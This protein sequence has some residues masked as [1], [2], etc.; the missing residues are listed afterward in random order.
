MAA[1]SVQSRVT[2]S[3]VFSNEHVAAQRFYMQVRQQSLALIE[4]LSAEDCALQASAFVS[5]A[6]WHLA[7]TTW[8]FET[9]ILIPNISGYE[10]FN[11]HFQVLFNS[12]YNG[13]GE[14]F[15]RPKRH[16]LSRPSL[17][18]VQLYRE[19]VDQ[20]M[21]QCLSV[22]FTKNQPEVAKLITLGLHHEM[23]H[24]ELLLMDLKYSFFQNPLFPVYSNSRLPISNTALPLV[25]DSIKGGIQQFGHQGDEFHF[26]NE[27]PRH[28]QFVADFKMANRQ[29]TNGEYLEFM[30][31]GGYESALLWLSDGWA[32]LK[33][34]N[35]NAAPLYWVMQQDQWFEFTLHGL[36]AL[37]LNAP[38]SHINFYEAH[39]YS[40]WA[41]KRLPTESEWEMVANQSDE[42][43]TNPAFG[44]SFN[45][46]NSECLFNQNWIWT[47][48]AY[49]PYPG[50]K[51]AEGAVGEYNGKFMC[52]QMVLRGGCALTPS[53]HLRSTY[54]NF[55]YPQDRWPMTGLRLAD[56]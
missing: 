39:A 56:N 40:Q 22:N 42:S 12:Y 49:Q 21:Q 46:T 23:Q 14:Q 55:F 2:P 15:L 50:Y 35:Q 16:L 4:P 43:L 26:D 52:N 36:Q 9:F 27:Q 6:K 1:T 24:Q 19:H 53:G 44:Q 10:P 13:V 47:S 11:T 30:K 33:Q 51:A 20:A 18:E 25:F 48:S 28:K 41:Q 5:P 3:T 32:W 34:E 31:D 8:F 37:D 7:H 17:A 45:S 54:R 38:V 29:I